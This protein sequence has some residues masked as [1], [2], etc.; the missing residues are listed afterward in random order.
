M[1]N[2]K[3]T[4]REEL[5]HITPRGDREQ[6]K[7]GQLQAGAQLQ[8]IQLTILLLF[9]LH[10]CLSFLPEHRWPSRHCHCRRWWRQH[11]CMGHHHR[12][13]HPLAPSWCDVVLALVAPRTCQCIVRRQQ[14]HPLQL[15][16]QQS[17]LS[18]CWATCCYC[19]CCCCCMQHQVLLLSLPVS[20]SWW[21]MCCT[22]RAAPR[23]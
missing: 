8:L 17:R 20:V 7:R 13:L 2:I 9:I 3:M 4:C 15:Q 22:C 5:K 1:S 6:L 19:C 21:P 12:W 11:R 10:L 23:R 16:L 18:C 14:A